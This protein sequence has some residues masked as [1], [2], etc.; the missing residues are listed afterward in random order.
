M[1]ALWVLFA[2]FV[3]LYEGYLGVLPTLELWGE[4]FYLKLGTAAKDEATQCGACATVRCT[5]SGVHFPALAVLQSARLWQK[6]YFYVQY[7]CDA[8]PHQPAGLRSRPAC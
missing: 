1:V 4:V 3:T 7:T 5:G 6:S 8:G 2:A